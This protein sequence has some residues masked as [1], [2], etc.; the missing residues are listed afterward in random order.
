MQ[1]SI[2]ETRKQNFYMQKIK[3]VI[4]DYGNVIFMIDFPKV[5][6]AFIDLGIKNVDDFFGHHGQDSLFDSFDKGEITVPEFRDGVREKA[7]KFDLTD[8]EIDTAWNS[9]LIGVPEGKHQILENLRDNYRTFLCSNNNELHYAYCMNHIQEKYGVPSND[10]F[11]ER[12]YYSHLEHL[13]KP[14]AAIFERVLNENNLNPEES[15]FVDDSPQHLEGAK[16][17]GIQTVLCSKERPLEQIVADYK[18]Y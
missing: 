10:V 12:T 18:L 13:R 16:K 14:D 15:L 11:F 4:L 3:N 2:F 6:Q 17:L 5:R 9:L 1:L 7:N 8:D